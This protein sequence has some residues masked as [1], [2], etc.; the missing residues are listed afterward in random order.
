M[1]LR[2]S[3]L[4]TLIYYDV[5][6]MPLSFLEVH[7]FLINPARLSKLEKGLGNISLGD[8]GEELETSARAGLIDSK[9]GFYF[10]PGRGAIYD[11]RIEREKIT[12]AKWKKFL[13]LSRWFSVAPYLRGLFASGSMAINNAGP[14]SD[15]DVLVIA[16]SGRLYTCRFFLWCI[17]SL[18]GARR[19]R[20]DTMAPDKFCLNHYV[21]DIE[22]TIRHESLYNAQTY[23]N[24]K[25]VLIS[26]E[27][28][29][30][31]YASNI[32]INKFVHNFKI[33][34]EFVRRS[35]AKS[36]VLIFISKA[37]ER[38]FDSRLGDILER[39][40]QKYQQ[41]RIKENPITYERGGRVTFNENELEF[42]PRSFEA[43]VIKKYGQGL[44]KS[45]IVPYVEEQDSGL[46]P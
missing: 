1:Y 4:A 39:T 2:N 34:E 20:F 6:D 15:F 37:L 18:L 29:R 25:P 35:P 14:D 17:S 41:K 12:T 10:L 27:L 24:L 16:R 33:S 36:P 21:T 38:L 42:H 45:G 23:T 9:N 11:R 44:R 22:L 8:I 43:T 26:K 7:K 28:V 30:D 13:K 40:A 31:F 32:W 5:L 46:T 19:K 3:I